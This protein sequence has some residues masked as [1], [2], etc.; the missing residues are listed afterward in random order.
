MRVND[1]TE[2]TR[3][4]EGLRTELLAHC[5]RMLGSADDAED[6]VQE[7]YLRAWH[8]YDR[9]EGRASLR[10]WLYRIATS[11]C[12]RALEQRARR[13]LPAA[14]GAPS[15]DTEQELTPDTSVP[16]LQPLPDS[17]LDADP[18]AAAVS[19]EGIRLAF[20]AALQHLP[21]RQR[22][23]L[24]L[25]DVLR[26]R[27]AEVADLLE[28][29]T[30]AV[31]SALQRARARLD[32]LRLVEADLTEPAAPDRQALLDEFV[33]AFEGADVERLTALLRHDAIVEMPPYPT[34]YRGADR[35]GRILVRCNDGPGHFMLLP[36][37]ANRQ[38][39]YTVWQRGPDGIYQAYAVLVL[40]PTTTGIAH[41]TVFL[42]SE[43][44]AAFGFPPEI[45]PLTALAHR[46]LE[47][48]T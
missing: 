38:P 9:F 2:F 7:T 1:T 27:A 48:V 44:V 16:W 39:A 32:E 5:Y 37:R 29:S 33:T 8:A 47:G 15:D 12:L 35:C 24:I 36:T 14:L 26:W 18:A 13:P 40:T 11:A 10:T 3:A 20:V 25:R 42:E 22:A 28:T 17:R 6:L 4:A 31:N 41:L 19:R 43:L 45:D 46:T 21:A 34:W 30:A 23:V